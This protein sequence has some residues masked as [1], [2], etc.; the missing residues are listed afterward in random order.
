MRSRCTCRVEPKLD[1]K[2][3]GRLLA[4]LDRLQVVHTHR[5][6]QQ[7]ADQTNR[8]RRRTTCDACLRGRVAL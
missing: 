5:V 2:I 6:A 8:L 7:V 1:A 4:R 3:E